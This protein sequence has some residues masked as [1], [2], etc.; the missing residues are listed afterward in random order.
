M[1]ATKTPQSNRLR[2]CSIGINRFPLVGLVGF[3]RVLLGKNRFRLVWLINF[4]NRHQTKV[5]TVE[6]ALATT[7]VIYVGHLRTV[8]TNSKIFLPRFMI[9]QEL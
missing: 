2:S 8:P 5:E 3:F 1:T 7:A 4:F 9:M 6:K